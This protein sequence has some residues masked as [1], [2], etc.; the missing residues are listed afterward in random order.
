[1]SL[2][3]ALAQHN[4]TV[5]DVDG[6]ATQLAEAIDEAA[7]AGADLLVT[8]ELA[9][10]GYP[11]RDLLHRTG[12]LSRQ[13]AALEGLAERTEDGP[14]VVLGAVREAPGPGPPVS[15]TATALVDGE[16]ATTYAKRLLPT[17]DVFDEHRYFA[18]GDEPATVSVAGLTVGLSVCEDAWHDTKVTGRRRHAADP[19]A[20]LNADLIVTPSASPFSLDKP[21]RRERRFAAHADRTETPVAFVNQVGGNDDL[22]FD[23]HSLVAAEDGIIARAASFESDFTVVDLDVPVGDSGTTSETETRDPATE[24]ADRAS[25]AR[26]AITLGISDYFAKTGF[27]E[28]VVGLSGG[29]DSSVTVAL[30]AEALGAEN[31]Y[32]VS[33]PSTVTSDESV[34][35]A[36]V[37]ADRLGVE[38]DVVPIGGIVDAFAADVDVDLSGVTG[39]NLQARLRGDVLMSIA[40][41]R[42]ALVLTP[43]NKS[44]AAV[45][46]CTLYGDTVG[47]I[48][49]LGDCYKG[50]VYELAGQLNDTPPTGEA[51]I[52]ERVIQKAPTAELRD[53]QT[54]ADEL[55]AYDRLDPVLRAYV[56]GQATGEQLR[57]THPE[58]VVDEAL[59]RL[60]RSEFK[61]WQTPLALRITD[62]AFGR[63]WRYP[64]AA[65]YDHIR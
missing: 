14:A 58:A 55:P 51:P 61:R 37:V 64:I 18:P 22:L 19:L 42:D 12:L 65:S 62:K 26:Q 63:G 39:E 34:T 24:S 49:P 38:F 10:V 50:L 17:Y 46:Y 35:D 29:I 41:A 47:A 11:P 16:I 8:P 57:E 27:T 4:P 15:N 32:G 31:V 28:A 25:Q 52:P 48:A 40:N 5:G 60:T 45:G 7:A 2:R 56:H 23:G 6:N 9:L 1:M 20:E 36:R 59:A 54:D 3:L 44:E 43:D 30:A 33:L 53:D 13:R 21:A